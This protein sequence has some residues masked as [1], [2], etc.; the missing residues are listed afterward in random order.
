MNFNLF[1][2]ALLLFSQTEAATEEMVKGFHFIDNKVPKNRKIVDHTPT[3]G[4]YISF[5]LEFPIK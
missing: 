2:A 5:L 1:R 3:S 4:N